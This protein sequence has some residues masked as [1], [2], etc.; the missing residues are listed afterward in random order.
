MLFFNSK[1]YICGRFC[2]PFE[3]VWMKCSYKHRSPRS[4]P[5]NCRNQHQNHVVDFDQISHYDTIN[6]AAA[7]DVFESSYAFIL[8]GGNDSWNSVL[9]KQI[10]M[11]GVDS[12]TCS[13]AIPRVHVCTSELWRAFKFQL[14]EVFL[15][16]SPHFTLLGRY[17]DCGTL[18]PGGWEAEWSCQYRN[19]L[20][21]ENSNQYMSIQWWE[22]EIKCSNV[23]S[24][25]IHDLWL[26][27]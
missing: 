19:T 27:V 21:E 6:R 8:G 13:E 3:T 17:R 16:L 24:N 9:H 7:I 20:M 14:R 22:R 25:C 26:V 10:G 15:S 4:Q 18:W 5:V 1:L 2:K 11:V 23:G 12:R